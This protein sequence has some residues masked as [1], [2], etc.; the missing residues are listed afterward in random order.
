[1]TYP[2]TKPTRTTRKTAVASALVAA[3]GGS[4]LCSSA[5]AANLTFSFSGSSNEGLFTMLDPTGIPLANTSYPYYGDTTWGYGLRTQI[6]GTL[7][8]DT[9]T[10]SGSMSIGAFDFF[11]GG[12]AVAHDITFTDVSGDPVNS[13]GATL[14]LGN[15][16]F[17]WGGNNNIPVSIVWDAS[18]LV[19][20]INSG[21]TVGDTVTGGAGCT[22]CATPASDSIKKGK[23]PIGPAPLAT[24]VFDTSNTGAPNYI[25]T[26]PLS[27]DAA[28][29]GG[30]PM[31]TAPFPN[32]NA[33]F[34]VVTLKLID[35]GSGPVF[36]QPADV[37]FTA[38]QQ[39][40][41]ASIT[42]N[43]GTVADEGTGVTI[44]YSTDGGTTWHA[45]DG[46]T[47]PV[48][49]SATDTVTTLSVSWRA[50]SGGGSTS[51]KDQKVT[52]TITDTT[53]PVFAAPANVNVGVI[54]TADNVCFGTITATDNVDS[55]P[56]EQWS[57]DGFN[58]T[59]DNNTDNCS[60]GFGPSDNTVYWRA[61]DDTG[62]T[63]SHEQT[64]TLNLPAGITGKAC[65]IDTTTAGQR[66]VEAL[67]TMRGP[68][69][70]ITPAGVVDST[71]TGHIDTTV[72]C[73]PGTEDTCTDVGA[74]LT[75]QQPFYG[76]LW[77]ATPIRLFGPGDYTF[78]TCPLP[79]ANIGTPTEP[80][81]VSLVDGSSNCDDLTTPMPLTMHVGPG[82]LGAHMLFEW[83]GNQ[84]I[85]VVVVWDEG[86][87]DYML[88]TTDP[89]GDGIL[90][91]RMV[92]GPFKNWNAAFDLKT[93]S[94]VPPIAEGGFTTSIPVVRNPVSG[95]SPIPLTVDGTA[96]AVADPAAVQSC[97]GG[98]FGF[99]TD[100][101]QS[102][103]DGTGAYQYTQVVLPL[104]EAI[105]FWSQYRLFDSGSMTWGPFVIDGRN[106]V[107]TA[108]M[109]GVD[110]PEPGG[111]YQRA[112]AGR[113]N[114]QLGFGD[115]CVQLTIED[116]GPNDADGAADGQVADPGGVA[117]VPSPA[118]PS[119]Q[120]SGGGCSLSSTRTGSAQGGA[121]WIMGGLLGWLGWKRRSHKVH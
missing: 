93:A 114:D 72:V 115:G 10:M 13:G 50:T 62:N 104:S 22:S 23:Y 118:L 105:P 47:N 63:A 65:T 28:L 54:S 55:A 97:V 39:S 3:I 103:T 19:S 71:V 90:G 37:N 31:Q 53:P 89:D 27:N 25:G 21:L 49:V 96:P 14:L 60:T 58:W 6:S 75:T 100:R 106:S 73:A 43:L 95:K 66:A 116:G 83:S 51:F 40:T 42:V 112:Q 86:C 36:T 44:D 85:D 94:G 26:T 9:T 76:S 74:A 48:S 15:L 77:S 69:G 98:C 119:P 32:F 18:G 80:K 59:N 108:P 70:T 46:S 4:L 117:E 8:I 64:V 29:V 24:T 38:P 61:V 88:T 68:S 81:Y 57:L 5:L 35:D 84:A 11:S 91:S 34:D 56:L 111:T 67:F 109:D 102:A 2:I 20:A 16:L 101:M 107:M 1:M 17:D 7:T 92:D 45:D 30:T 78:E 113:I 121:W 110:C 82:Q 99:T 33:N 12:P 79:R 52:V 87:K 41:P 120:T